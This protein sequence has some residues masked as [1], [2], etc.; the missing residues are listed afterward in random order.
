MLLFYNKYIYPHL[1]I[2]LQL[3]ELFRTKEKPGAKQAPTYNSYIDLFR[4][5]RSSVKK[6][7]IHQMKLL[8]NLP[9]LGHKSKVIY[10]PVGSRSI[11]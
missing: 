5:L 11:F 4:W 8:L 3:D 2:Y 7:S 9:I 10:L 1:H 6:R